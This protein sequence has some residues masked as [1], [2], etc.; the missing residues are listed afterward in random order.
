MIQRSDRIA[1]KLKFRFLA[2]GMPKHSI[3]ST[4]DYR[5]HRD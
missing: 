2:Q 5:R 4:D 3:E 1:D